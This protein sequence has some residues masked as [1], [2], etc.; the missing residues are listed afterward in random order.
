[1][2]PPVA[3][4]PARFSRGSRAT[5]VA[6]A[7]LAVVVAI[8]VFR[9][10]TNLVEPGVVRGSGGD[11]RDATYLPAR[12]LLDGINPYDPVAYLS[13]STEV[14][15]Y[16]PVYGPHHLLLHLPLAALS[17]DTALAA[18]AGLTIILT[19]VLAWVSLGLA[20]WQR[21]TPIVLGTA[22]LLLISNPGR[23][24][25][26]DLQPTILI[27]LGIYLALSNRHSDW[28][29]A[30]GVALAFFKPQFGIPLVVILFF[31]GRAAVAWKGILVGAI[32]SAP[33]VARLI[34]IEGGIG[35]VIEALGDNL[36]HAADVGMSHLQVDLVSA[37]RVG[38]PVVTVV[39]AVVIL[40][41]AV[42]TLRNN[43]PVTTPTSLAIVT[44]AILLVFFHVN[45]DLLLLSW[46]I[47]ALAAT[48][49]R[50]RPDRV[51]KTLLILLLLLLFNPLTSS[52]AI[53]HLGPRD[54]LAAVSGILLLG[55]LGLAV[56]QQRTTAVPTPP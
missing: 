1:M 32:A 54:V 31:T 38:S 22:A 4:L 49:R 24:N 43:Q 37:L 42:S 16:F 9:L 12:A 3:I 33:V 18:Y 52:F 26:V 25:F 21:T 6:A 44:S 10:V 11:F 51:H 17:L 50:D 53:S 28:I 23:A 36:Q 19:V 41:V 7:A 30:F 5:W 39:V 27:V 35:G 40:G 15:D 45:Y 56:A 48:V 20:G 55:V 46:P 13:S 47:L 2:T 8:V 14:G 29:A 34:S